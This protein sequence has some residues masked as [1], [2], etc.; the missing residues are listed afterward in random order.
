M[1]NETKKTYSANWIIKLANKSY[2]PG[3]NAK[4]LYLTNYEAESL[5]ALGAIIEIADER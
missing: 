5:L 4:P 3:V 2:V 1:K